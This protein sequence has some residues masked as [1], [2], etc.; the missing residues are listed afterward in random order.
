MTVAQDL[1]QSALEAN[2]VVGVGQTPATPHLNR[3]LS[4]LQRMTDSW[5][6]QPHACFAWRII[7]VPL[8]VNQQTYTVGI[9]GQ[10]NVVRPQEILSG[11]GAAYITDTNF[12]RYP[13]NVVEQDYWQLIGNV[14]SVNSQV[15]DTVWYDPQ[16]PLGI[17]NVFPLPYIAYTL[18]L[19]TE[20]ELVNFATLQTAFNMPP[21]YQ[22]AIELNLAVELKEYFPAG[23]PLKPSLI[24]AAQ[25]ALGDVKRK[26]ITQVVAI[27]DNE[28]VSRG[29]PA[30]N[31]YTDR[32]GGNV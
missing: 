4:V 3:G 24:K 12:N 14:G 32:G 22:R 21:G 1:I 15:P 29:T 16:F 25:D 18:T 13:V 30:Y 31:V 27:H 20:L 10:V 5:S 7:N 8:V 9:G 28:I 2:G 11:P 26:N 19:S 17:I 6:T 23:G